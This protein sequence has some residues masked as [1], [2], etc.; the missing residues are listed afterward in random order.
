MTVIRQVMGK[1]ASFRRRILLAARQLLPR[2]ALGLAVVSMAVTAGL[3]LAREVA[4]ELAPDARLVSPE[5]GF[6]LMDRRG[7][8]LDEVE[9]AEGKGFGY[10]SLES[11]P[12]RVVAA[13]LVAEDRRFY[14]HPG[15]DPLASMRA[16]WQNMRSGRRISGASTLA[17]QVARMQEPG[18]RT[19]RKKI[20][21]GLQALALI[22]TH[23]RDAVLAHYLR[24]V[25]YG[26]RIH[27]IAYAAR[28]YFGKPVEDLSWAEIALL[29]AIPQAPG[30]MNPCTPSGR[31]DAVRR[32]EA[33]LHA[34]SR[35]GGL[36]PGEYAVAL[37]EIRRMDIPPLA[38]RPV[39]AMHAVL[40]MEERLK[41]PR[42]RRALGG[43]RLVTLSLD[44][45]LQ[46]E[47]VRVVVDAL[48]SWDRQSAG[49]AALILVDRTSTEVLAWVGSS[50]YFDARRTGAIDYARIPRPAGSTLKPLL[51]AYALDRGIITP[52]T[53]LDDL[54][55]GP[56]SIENSDALFLGPLL[57]R[58]AL[59]NSRN[60]PAA[61]LLE[62]RVGIEEGYAFF[63][64]LG[65]HRY[66]HP[67][68]H[69]GAGLAVG[70]LPVT[71][72]R[73]VRAYTSLSADGS[74][75]DLVWTKEIPQPSPR[76]LLS[77]ASAR[78][79]ALFLSDPMARLPS[80]PRMGGTEFPFP[81]AVKTGTSAGYRDA[82]VVAYS[83]KYLVGVW[84]GN[85]D[86]AP[87]K[88]LS[89][90]TAAAGI[91]R[92]MLSLLHAGQESGFDDHVFPPPKGFRP[93]NICALTGQRATAACN[94]IF[95]EWFHPGR[96]P[97][98]PCRGH[99]SVSVDIRNGRPAGRSTPPS[100][101]EVR[102][103]V[104]LDAK[105][106]AWAAAEGLSRPPAPVM[107][108]PPNREAARTPTLSAGR[109]V[110]M[111]I[112]SPENGVSLRSDPEMPPKLATVALE[113]VVDPPVAQVVWFVDG[114]PYKVVDFPYTA[115]WPVQ[116][117]EHSFQVRLPFSDAAS[118]PVM[119]RVQ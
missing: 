83:L 86:V 52:A 39:E 28:R 42:L 95:L 80:F 119:V 18:P 23:G 53:V 45:D 59:A 82:W 88:G 64:R 100:F 85:P 106:A 94:R 78:Q 14:S 46:R 98:V 107:D 29:A 3:Y 40:A 110:S 30:R 26:N 31:N 114:A 65:L 5:P 1:E 116:T 44:L 118:A 33:I 70:A 97:V 15:V 117:G 22:R 21:E 60:V 72:E 68:R 57:P 58:E 20:R 108:R 104:D 9:G 2:A 27:G 49:N 54:R 43:R 55:R 63:G 81:V 8:F 51:Y 111:N 67:P 79:V 87:M 102:T 35:R 90:F 61:R 99:V 105:Y 113:A 37:D 16:A 84:V 6:L 115:R 25:P 36:S 62:H 47:A 91:V 93:V 103:F 109:E 50:G 92:P 71:L 69:Y 66:E 41:E 76:K 7:R 17:M 10:W 75:G 96:G 11:L 89:G 48:R 73:L 19:F 112:V 56:G 32:G 74:L 12:P 13:T 77:E 34:L 101:V 4:I 38:R 24:I